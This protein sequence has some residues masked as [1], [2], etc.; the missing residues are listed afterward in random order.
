MAVLVAKRSTR[1]SDC[2]D[3]DW[4][5]WNAS[6][7]HTFVDPL[8]GGGRMNAATTEEIV[9]RIECLGSST[10]WRL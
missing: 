3:G 6:G 4:N 9:E 8:Y 7:M 5:A 10:D 2:A 1:V